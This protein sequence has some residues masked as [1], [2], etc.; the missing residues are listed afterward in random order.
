MVIDETDD[1]LLVLRALRHP[2][3]EVQFERVLAAVC[4]LPDVAQR[5]ATTVIRHASSGHPDAVARLGDPP[6]DLR[7]SREQVMAEL[8][9]GRRGLRRVWR[10]GRADLQLVSASGWELIVELKINAEID[11]KQIDR[12]LKDAPTVVLARGPGKT[13]ISTW[14]SN[15]RWLGL[16][17]W[18]DVLDDLRDFQLHGAVGS[19]WHRILAVADS[20][21]DF[22]PKKPVA[23][24]EAQAAADLLQS[25]SETLTEHLRAEVRRV[26]DAKG[27]Q[28]AGRLRAY[29][30]YPVASTAAVLPI[31][32]A[33]Q[34]SYFI[35]RLS[36]LFRTPSLRI[37]R[38]MDREWRRGVGSTSPA[39]R[40]RELLARAGTR[41][42]RPKPANSDTPTPHASG[43]RTSSRRSSNAVHS[44]PMFKVSP[45]NRLA[46]SLSTDRLGPAA[47]A[48]AVKCPESGRTAIALAR[49]NA[50]R[51]RD[52]MPS[53]D[54]STRPE[55][56]AWPILHGYPHGSWPGA[57]RVLS[58]EAA[59]ATAP[60]EP[61]VALVDPT[62]ASIGDS[63]EDGE[64]LRGESHRQR[65]RLPCDPVAADP[66]AVN[67]P[68][69]TATAADQPGARALSFA[70]IGFLD[71]RFATQTLVVSR[72][73]QGRVAAQCAME[74]SR[75]GR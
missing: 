13:D 50:L 41:R 70:Q 55:R 46:S 37:E 20:D 57:M 72:C 21:H 24:V 56:T 68:R 67:R 8:A 47:I 54:T 73:A 22:K 15:E 5:F 66:L 34:P 33:T 58:R 61:R 6:A 9:I 51:R 28:L 2:G 30:A 40:G 36:G 11:P 32:V 17:R 63:L 69:R 1:D 65:R 7:T 43:S 48:F 19:D 18:T 26:H 29:K 53:A 12:Y 16:A 44:P 60:A 59:R 74:R 3:D 75:M 52:V 38:S 39:R 4:A 71:E 25:I 10:S 35:I 42:R 31:G 23:S 62:I 14:R 27:E 64:V 49:H 45:D